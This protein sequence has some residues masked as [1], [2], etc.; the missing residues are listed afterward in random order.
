MTEL[1]FFG[2]YSIIWQ[3]AGLRQVLDALWMEP[4]WVAH[5]RRTSA[6]VRPL[7]S[8]P[9]KPYTD[10]LMPCQCV[11]ERGTSSGTKQHTSTQSCTHA[12]MHVRTHTHTHTPA[13]Y[14]SLDLK[15]S[16]METQQRG[17]RLLV[18]DIKFKCVLLWKSKKKPSHKPF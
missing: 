13:S 9:P 10:A 15:D 4:V 1:W 18:R 16:T 5:Y 8:A 12:H 14:G 11:C 3:L 6:A 7:D 17:L 2:G